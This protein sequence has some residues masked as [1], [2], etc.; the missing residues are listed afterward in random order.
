MSNVED[1]SLYIEFKI[2]GRS[3]YFSVIN[4]DYHDD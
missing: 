2:T 3:S 1:R 4:G